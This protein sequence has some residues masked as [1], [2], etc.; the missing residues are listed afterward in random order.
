MPVGGYHAWPMRARLILLLLVCVLVACGDKIGD[1]CDYNVDC[2]PMGD[3]ICDTS[4]LEGYCTIQGCDRDSCPEDEAV[5]IRFYP[6]SFLS[7]ACDPK[8]EDAPGST[9]GME[10][11]ADCSSTCKKGDVCCRTNNCNSD[12]ICL[13]SGFCAQRTQERRFCMLVCDDDTDCRD[14]YQC[15]KSGTRGA[16]A[17]P[18]PDDS[19]LLQVKFCAQKI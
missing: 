2:S 9:C 11:K 15:R 6:V 3:R 14:G 7:V 19:G 5:C 10:C 16:E 8:T 17:V 4:Q 12:E 18:H 13:S 1:S